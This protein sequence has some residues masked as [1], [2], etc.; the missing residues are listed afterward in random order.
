MIP[1]SSF[2]SFTEDLRSLIRHWR[3]ITLRKLLYLPRILKSEERR[4]LIFLFIIAAISAAGIFG[5]VYVR[6]TSPIPAVGGSHVE[7]MLKEPRVINPVFA[8]QD[9]E[10][11]LARLLFSGLVTYSSRGVA[12]PDL[13]ERYEISNDGKIYTVTLRPELYWHDG[14]RLDADD[15]IFTV[16]MIQNPIYKSPLRVNWQGVTAEK[17][18]PRTAQFTLRTPYAPFIENFT[19]GI[20]PKHLWEQVDPVHALR[21]ELNLKPVGSG[22]YVFDRLKQAKD[23]SLISYQL[24]RNTRY[25]REG[26]Y[27]KRMIFLFFKTEEELLGAWRKGIVEA[28]GTAPPSLHPE[29]ASHRSRLASLGM[30]RIFGLFFN[31]KK[32][33]FLASHKMREAIA[34]AL[35]KET[36]IERVL[37]GGAA[38]ADLPLPWISVKNSP[39]A[40]E[41]TLFAYNPDRS[42]ELLEK[43]GWKDGDGDGIREKRSRSKGKETVTPL[44]ITLVTSDWPDL[45]RSGKEIKTMLKDIGMD[46][47]VESRPFAELEASVIRPRNFELLLFGQ[48]YGYEPDPFAFWHSSQIKDPGLNI[49]FYANKKADKI[50]EDTRKT[51]DPAARDAGYLAFSDILIKDLPAVFLFSQLYTY[52]LPEALH[53]VDLARISLPADRFNEANRWYKTTDR[54]FR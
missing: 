14:E 15:V 44:R 53:G 30:P 5:R 17:L 35:N 19:V 41:E 34:R 45:V 47:A 51:S 33:P 13:A 10:R 46:V 7:G 29:L 16:R 39:D 6:L 31:E 42:R 38:P 22:P 1:S 4:L 27:L 23:G 40:A 24:T 9:P 12:E 21:H 36:I 32:Q 2:K 54:V 3:G 11:D 25:H 50:L 37:S 26:P 20:L 28:L 49:S 52:L 43:E 18:D 48:V 8:S